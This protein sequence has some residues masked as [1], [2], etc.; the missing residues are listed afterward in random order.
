M[1]KR[2][3]YTE[4]SKHVGGQELQ[5]MMQLQALQH[6]GFEVLLA[7]RPESE[8]AT[9]AAEKH[10][11]IY[12]ITFRN[13]YHFPSL[14]R[15]RQLI[16]EYHPLFV[17]SHSGHDANIAA[18]A[19]KLTWNKPTLVRQKT[20]LTSRIKPFSTNYLADQV[21]VPSSG[22]KRAMVAGGC[23]DEKIEVVAPGFDF[24]TLHAQSE[25]PLPVSVQ[26]WL[27]AGTSPVIVQVGMLR[28][29]K[30]HDTALAAFAALKQSG[31]AFRYLIV[32]DGPEYKVINAMIARYG[33]QDNVLMA[34]KLFPA[35]AVY[36][37]ADLV[38]MPSRN[39][40]FGMALV[41]AMYFGV[42]VMASD[43]GGIPDVIRH[44][45]NGVLLPCDDVAAWQN[46]IAD[47]LMHPAPYRQSARHAS[48]DVMLR[49]SIDACV[50]KIIALSY[51]EPTP[52]VAGVAK[53]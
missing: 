20:Y 5:A 43:V 50:K 8:V 26:C 29:E 2:I 49:Y 9:L 15:F 1:R 7:C 47:F 28:G 27:E 45:E 38:L 31:H 24:A 19:T 37:H 23:R 33:L 53:P 44:Q 22:M 4:S 39:E 51:K 18:L 6:L 46:A 10:I 32:G 41:E 30:G 13:S 34:G 40:S 21:V 35:A 25:R 17:V 52:A 42:P 14:W 12:P 48:D 36:R 11:P 3:L 16:N